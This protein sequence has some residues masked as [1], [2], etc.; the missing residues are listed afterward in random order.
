MCYTYLKLIRKGMKK[1]AYLELKTK[2]ELEAIYNSTERRF[3]NGTQGEFARRGVA[4]L[5]EKEYD[6]CPAGEIRWK[7]NGHIV[8]G[9]ILEMAVVDGTITI[10][11][12]NKSEDLRKIEDEIF[13]KNYINFRQKHGYSEEELMEINAEFGDDEPVDIFT[14]REI[15]TGRFVL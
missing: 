7:S 6:V 8:P 11:Q 15:R 13:I 9:D 14:G 4:V 2:Q 5:A 1:M 10:E 12:R 3:S